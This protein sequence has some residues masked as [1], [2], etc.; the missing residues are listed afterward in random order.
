MPDLMHFAFIDESGTVG[1]P[2]GTHFLVVALLSTGQPREIELPIRHAMKKYGPSL[3]RGEIKAANF[4]EKAITRLLTEIAKENVSIFATIVDQS[5]IV[6]PPAEMEEI[7]RRAVS[8]T[9]YKLVEQCP[10]VNICLDRRYTN[11]RHRFELESK[12]RESIQD[13]PQKVVMIQQENSISRKE[14]QAVDAVAWAFFQKYE[15]DNASFYELISSKIIAEE[16]IQER[17]W[18]K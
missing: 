1:I 10:R 12:I 14:L 3:S 18:T 7:Y 17:D 9:V 13:L 2:G 6:K 11:E 16:I 15:R 8:K 4:E 5:V